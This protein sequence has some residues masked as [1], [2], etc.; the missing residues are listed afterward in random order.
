MKNRIYFFTG[1]GNSYHLAK[2]IAD[3]LP[4]CDLEAIYAEMDTTVPAGLER[5]GFVFP[6]YYRGLPSMVAEF[7]K[8]AA[9]PAQG[10]TY[11][12]SIATYGGM[13]GKTNAQ[14]SALLAKK[15]ITL[16]YGGG[17]RMFPNYVVKYNM[18]LNPEKTAKS[19]DKRAVS[20][21]RNIVGKKIKPAAPTAQM[22]DYYNEAI[23]GV[24]S[25]DKG[26]Q[27]SDAC[28][29][30]GVCASVC[31]AKNI[32]LEDGKPT[33]HHKCEQCVACIQHCPK[34]AIDFEDKTQARKRYT[35]PMVKSGELAKYYK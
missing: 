17:L 26:Y 13:V 16:N 11:V 10:D 28:T 7:L 30:C 20:I 3:K 29:S 6:V 21:I 24:H 19:A 32:T 9:F 14:V 4:E 27:I 23:G 35:H 12:F 25:I 18:F 22:S 34:R 31:P 33:F 1:T 2:Q 15:N 5:I 8:N